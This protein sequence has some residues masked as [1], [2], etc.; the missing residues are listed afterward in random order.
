MKIPPSNT[1]K[2]TFGYLNRIGFL[3]SPGIQALLDSLEEE[4]LKEISN[5][6]LDIHIDQEGQRTP[7]H[8]E[9][10]AF[11]LL[12]EFTDKLLKDKS[13]AE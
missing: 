10:P 9:W 11:A 2:V 13:V 1:E 7:T 3:D 6:I 8:I 4:Q 5:V 12:W